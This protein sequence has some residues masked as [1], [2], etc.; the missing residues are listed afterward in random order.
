MKNTLLIDANSIFYASQHATKLNSGDMQTQAV[1]GA[2]KTARELRV[3]YPNFSQ[4]W[5]HDSRATWRFELHP[6]YKSGRSDTPDKVAAKAALEEQRPYIKRAFS[7]LGLRQ[8][9]VDGYEADDTIGYLSAQLAATPGSQ[10]GIISGDQDLCQLVKPNVFWRDMRDDSKI[11][12]HVTLMNKTGFPTPYSFLEGKCLTGDSSDKI[13]GVGGIGDTG[14]PEFIA[15]FGSVREFWRRCDAG[16]FIPTKKSHLSLW[17]GVSPHTKE[18]WVAQQVLTCEM[19]TEKETAKLTKQ[20]ADQWLGQGRKIFARNFRLMQLLR[21]PKPDKEKVKVVSG[22]FNDDKF[23]E[24]CEELSFMSI[25]RHQENF[26]K[27]F[28]E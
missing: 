4:I 19:R 22:G 23:T 7:A 5:C 13:P 15:E 24:V 20:W 6:G 16:E 12:T 10:V 11:I 2:L 26:T 21:V 18:E 8:I 14:A 3:L 17:K 28:K 9:T 27:P 25:L 1:F